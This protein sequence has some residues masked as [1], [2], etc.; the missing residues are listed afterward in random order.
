MILP[1]S[2][3]SVFAKVTIMMAVAFL[4]GVGLCGLDF[5]LASDGIGKNTQEFGVG[6]LDGLSLVVMILSALG[7]ALTL[8]LWIV[9]A[10]VRSFSHKESEPQKLLD[11]QDQ[12]KH[13]DQP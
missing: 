11:A 6:P 12:T 8:I 3:M 4:V 5:A 2:K 10:I 13:D 7:L 1:K 9:V